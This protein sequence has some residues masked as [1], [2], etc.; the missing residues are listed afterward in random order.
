MRVFG[1]YVGGGRGAT[2]W[3]FQVGPVYVHFLRS[4]V[5]CW[6]NFPLVKF[7]WDESGGREE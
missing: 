6:G 7:Y 4:N 3:E 5:W 2:A 1:Y